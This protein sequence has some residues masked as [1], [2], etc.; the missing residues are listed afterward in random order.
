MLSF[1]MFGAFVLFVALLIHLLGAAVTVGVRRLHHWYRPLPRARGKQIQR[2]TFAREVRQVAV[3]TVYVENLMFAAAL[4]GICRMVLFL[5]FL[6]ITAWAW[7]RSVVRLVAACT[8]SAG[9]WL[10]TKAFLL[11]NPMG[12]DR[13]C[14]VRDQFGANL[15][16]AMENGRL[17]LAPQE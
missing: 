4:S 8:R 16:D 14:R 15:L 2:P 5:I 6:P 1:L 11:L 12:G 7:C 10:L 9:S 17:Q 13:E 3:N